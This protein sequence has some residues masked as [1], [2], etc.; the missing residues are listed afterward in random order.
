MWLHQQLSL[1][2]RK[3]LVMTFKRVLLCNEMAAVSD[4]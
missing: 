3:I 1:I 4:P 2:K